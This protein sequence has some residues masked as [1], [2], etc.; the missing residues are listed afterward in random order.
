MTEPRGITVLGSTGSISV[1]T[2]DVISR[3]R[4]RFQVIA[5]SANSQVE[6][7]FNQCVEFRPRYAAL[8]SP[9]RAEELH[10]KIQ[11]ANLKT[12]VLAGIDALEKIAALP[13][14][15]CVMAALFGGAGL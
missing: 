4:D 5:L 9:E 7:L 14:V 1:N 15:D 3:H 10:R 13:E 2:L 11:S 6:Q 12:E 8:A